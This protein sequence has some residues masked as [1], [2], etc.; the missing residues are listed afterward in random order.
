M[1][2]NA[3]PFSHLDDNKFA[4]VIYE[5]RNEPVR[6]SQG[7]NLS[8]RKI[9]YTFERYLLNPSPQKEL[10]YKTYKNKFLTNCKTL[11]LQ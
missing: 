3:L 11:I 1:S 9:N 10:I 4:A 6:I 7:L 8:S 5:F 2:V